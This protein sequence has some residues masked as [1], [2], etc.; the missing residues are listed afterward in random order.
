[1]YVQLSLNEGSIYSVTVNNGG[2][3]CEAI[4]ILTYMFSLFWKNI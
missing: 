1:M 2:G 3:E 4:L